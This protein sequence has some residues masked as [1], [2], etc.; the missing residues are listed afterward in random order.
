MLSVPLTCFHLSICL[1]AGKCQASSHL[2][3]TKVYHNRTGY[4][5]TGWGL[6][7]CHL[8]RLMGV[9]SVEQIT[10][11][12]FWLDALGLPCEHAWITSYCSLT[13]YM[14]FPCMMQGDNEN[15]KVNLVFTTCLQLNRFYCHIW[16]WNGLVSHMALY[17]IPF[18]FKTFSIIELHQ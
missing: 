13:M 11:V 1:L 12:T 10:C 7:A 18:G 15:I 3:I 2:S 6:M 8:Y 16:S 17:N 14:S 4:M 5:G 9:M